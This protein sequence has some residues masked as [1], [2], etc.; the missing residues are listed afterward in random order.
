MPS[1]WM[2]SLT[3]LRA[4]FFQQDIR[5]EIA[6]AHD[7]QTGQ[8]SESIRFTNSLDRASAPRHRFT[9]KENL[10]PSAML[11]NELMIGRRPSSESIPSSP[12]GTLPSSHG[13]YRAGRVK[14][15]ICVQEIFVI[16]FQVLEGN[17]YQFVLLFFK[18]GCQI[19]HGRNCIK[20]PS[21][22][23]D[24]VLEAWWRISFAGLYSGEFIQFLACSMLSN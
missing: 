22:T 14:R 24:R 9:I 15:L 19:K 3:F 5:G 17:R 12:G 13:L 8:F 7:H 20:G 6:A 18:D 4:D 10:L 11:V 2:K 16:G 21:T 23:I 1:A